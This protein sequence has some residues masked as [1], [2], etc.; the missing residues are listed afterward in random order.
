M[1]FIG[2]TTL[3]QS[4]LCYSNVICIRWLSSGLFCS[5]NIVS[6]TFP[7]H[8]LTLKFQDISRTWK[9]NLLFSRFSRTRGNPAYILKSFWEYIFDNNICIQSLLHFVGEKYVFV[10]QTA[11]CERVHQSVKYYHL[12]ARR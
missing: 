5:G 3:L 1:T 2:P 6:R 12:L 10:E 9:M 11:F 4:K 7:G 8:F